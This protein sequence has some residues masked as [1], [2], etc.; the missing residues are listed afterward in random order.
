LGG[1]EALHYV[2]EGQGP[3]VVFVHGNP[4]WSFMWR[5]LIEGLAGHRRLAVDHL[6]MGLSS[7]PERPLRLA[8]RV[9]H[10]GLWLDSLEIKEKIHLAVHDW[11]GPIGLGWAARHPERVA[12]LVIMNTGLRRP[13]GYKLP[14]RLG[15]FAAGALF[16]SLLA[17]ELNLFVQGLIRSGTF[18]P[19]TKAAQSGFL[20]PYALAAHRR[21]IGGFIRDIPLARRHPS[22]GARAE[23]DALFG[24]LARLPVLLAWGLGDFVFDR[25][26]LDD[27]QGRCPQARVLALESAGH[28]LLEDKP[29]AV[30]SALRS[31]LA[32]A[33]G[34]RDPFDLPA[35]LAAGG[36]APSPLPGAGG[37][38]SAPGPPGLLER[39]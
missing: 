28:W 2:D 33:G 31:H 25:S 37:A 7:R 3:P 10:L 24:A 26:F 39:S 35:G 4:A 9:E 1:G 27:F 16:S 36:P 6:G 12:S 17:V 23:T 15:L 14:K 18:R 30:L 34:T 38:D 11:G 8:E 21:A 22:F 13:K 20:A 19:L 29:E 5:R 32:Q